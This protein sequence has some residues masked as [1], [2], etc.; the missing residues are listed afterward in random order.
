[1]TTQAYP[2]MAVIP[3]RGG[4]KRL[5]S[6]NLHPLAGQPL[7][8]H[9]I[10][11][12]IEARWVAAV[13]VSTDSAEIAEMAE[14]HGASVI[15]RP[16]DIAGDTASSESAMLHALDAIEAEHGS[17]QA[18]M[19]LQCT[20]P[21]RRRRDIDDAIEQ[22][23]AERA[24]SLLSACRTKHFLWR[25]NPSGAFPI[26]YDLGFRPRSQDIEAQFQENGSIY[27][28]KTDLLRKSGNRLGGRIAVYEMDFWS[29]FEID[30]AND[31]AL[32]EWIFQ[33]QNV[34]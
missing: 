30:D 11:Q 33:R 6:K 9:T 8:A 13:F 18:V 22:F 34:E 4:S 5:P 20:S 14:A 15:R 12:A 24:D 1:M 25:R 27:I 2:M 23:F 21:V 3:A 28:T 31:L 7:V 26:N 17:Q 16:D 32:I 19:M 10:R 29:Q